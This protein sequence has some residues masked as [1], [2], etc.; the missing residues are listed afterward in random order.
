MPSDAAGR[1]GDRELSCCSLGVPFAV[2]HPCRTGEPEPRGIAQP[3]AGYHPVGAGGAGHREPSSRRAPATSATS[4]SVPLS[5]ARGR[6]ILALRRQLQLDV[7]YQLLVAT[8]SQGSSGPCA[9]L[10]RAAG[11]GA[12]SH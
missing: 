8:P 9:G 10:A 11:R 3:F 1:A 7:L 6:L 5:T 2:Y 12:G 4:C